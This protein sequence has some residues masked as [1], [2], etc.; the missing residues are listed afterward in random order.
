[1]FESWRRVNNALCHLVHECTPG[2]KQRRN[3]SRCNKCPTTTSNRIL[4]CATTDVP[5]ST[6][7]GDTLTSWSLASSGRGNGAK[8]T[9]AS[10]RACG[11][12]LDVTVV[13][14]YNLEKVDTRQDEGKSGVRYGGHYISWLATERLSV[15]LSSIDT[16]IEA[17]VEMLME[18]ASTEASM[19]A[20]RK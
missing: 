15:S 10:E 6:R 4:V 7:D 3:T 12:L 19:K 14:T 16:F 20:S 11:V 18:V 1:M 8:E 17:D 13:S 5:P 9:G 2:Q